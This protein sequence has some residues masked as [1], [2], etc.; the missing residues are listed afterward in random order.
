MRKRAVG[1]QGRDSGIKWV[2]ELDDV[3]VFKSEKERERERERD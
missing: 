1:V 3:C 2:L